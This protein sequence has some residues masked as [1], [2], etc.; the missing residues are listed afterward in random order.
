MRL[1]CSGWTI[2]SL[3]LVDHVIHLLRRPTR[4]NRDVASITSQLA[5]AQDANV[6]PQ[7]YN[8]PRHST[9]SYK[10]VAILLRSAHNRK[11]FM[12]DVATEKR[13]EGP[14]QLL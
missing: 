6:I 4:S 8:W 12:A 5:L 14:S 13:S 9:T 10:F 11:I 7:R 2:V 3:Y 1:G